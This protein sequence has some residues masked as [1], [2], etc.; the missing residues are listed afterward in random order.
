MINMVTKVIL[1]LIMPI[2]IHGK[3]SLINENFSRQV[4][5][6]L[7][8]YVYTYSHPIT[9]KIF[10]VGKGEGN[11]VFDH[12]KD[13]TVNSKKSNL[14]N[15]LKKQGLKPKIEILIHG[16]E[17]EDVAYKVESAIIDLLRVDNLTN[18]QNGHDSK[19][20]GRMSIEQIK[21]VYLEN[22]MGKI[23]K[24]MF[25]KAYEIYLTP[26]KDIKPLLEMG[27]NPTSAK[28]TIN[29]Y[30]HILKGKL[31]KRTASA[32][33]IEFILEKLFKNHDKKKIIFS[34]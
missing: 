29:W 10:Y 30:E 16:L 31:Y 11:R 27:M 34:T 7:K 17:N 20:L 6:K 24:E 12:L 33:Q 9:N 2:L 1:I 13:T 25:E 21:I 18:I 8:Y 4:A 22:D 5:T 14:I 23:T 3:D 19:K 15:E 26:A 32:L 28:M